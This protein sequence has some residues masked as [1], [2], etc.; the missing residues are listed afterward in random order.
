MSTWYGYVCL[1]HEPPLEGDRSF[2]GYK[3]EQFLIWNL[4]R[5]RGQVQETANYHDQ[6]GTANAWLDEHE[7]CNVGVKDGYGKTVYTYN[8]AVTGQPKLFVENDKG[9]LE[10]Y[11]PEIPMPAVTKATEIEPGKQYLL[12]MG[13]SLTNEQADAMHARLKDRFPTNT[14]VLASPNI[15]VVPVAPLAQGGPVTTGEPFAKEA[16]EV[17]VP[18]GEN[19]PEPMVPAQI[20]EMRRTRLPQPHAVRQND[21]VAA[22]RK[23]AQA[24]PPH[25]ETH[26]V[27]SLLA[28]ELVDPKAASGYAYG[29][30]V[31]PEQF[32]QAKGP[33][34]PVPN[35]NCVKPHPWLPGIYC[36]RKPH[37]KTERHYSHPPEA[38]PHGTVINWVSK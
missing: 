13:G 24:F 15:A 22:L 18:Y 36:D 2:H 27:L 9:Q 12:S 28:R 8:R 20:Q 23:V 26:H 19:G 7:D 21:L 37:N 6:N 10:P 30:P 3:G 11:V 38:Q 5:R 16:G 32:E 33:E 29:R 34:A 1:S 35:G 17:F 14:F 31:T 25:T 4:K